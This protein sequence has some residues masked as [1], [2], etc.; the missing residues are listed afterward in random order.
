MTEPGPVGTVQA[1]YVALDTQKASWALVTELVEASL[2]F[3]VEPSAASWVFV[4]DPLAASWVP[5][6]A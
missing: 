1:A 5:V 4:V 2:V 3:V 6:E